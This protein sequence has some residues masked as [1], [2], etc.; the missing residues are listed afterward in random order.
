MTREQLII[1]VLKEGAIGGA[2]L[3]LLA[4]LLSRFVRDVAGRGLL[5]I[6]LMTAAGAYFGFAVAGGPGPGW[7]LLELA[8]VIV[9]GVPALLGLRGSPFWLAAGWALHPV[10]DAGLHYVGP[11]RTFA[12]M[13]YVIACISFDLVV[14]A[15]IMIAYGL[16]GLGRASSGSSG[17][18]RFGRVA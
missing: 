17:S 1:A 18:K 7:T 5:S 11:G 9:F 12:P 6:L 4:F 16:V 14:G 15:Y 2:V 3:S 8:Q 10:W 13:P